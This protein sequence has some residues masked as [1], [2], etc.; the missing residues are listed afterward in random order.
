MGYK[1]KILPIK[2]FS[3]RPGRPF[4]GGFEAIVYAADHGCRV[5]NLSWGSVGSKS[6]YEQ[7]V[8]NYAAIN[9]DAVIVAAAGND[10]RDADYYPAS[11]NNVISVAALTAADTQ[12]ATYSN[13]VTLSAPGYDILTA[14]YPNDN[15][16]A[17]VRGSSF[18]APIVA[19]AAALVRVRFP[20]YTAAQVAAQLRQTTDDIY[21]LPA[22]TP[23]RGKLGTGRLNVHRAVALTDRRQVRVVASQFAPQRTYFRPGEAVRLTAE[24]Q[25]QLRA[26]SGLT[27][28]LTSLSPFLS[29]QRGSYAVGAMPTLGRATTASSPFLLTVAANTP[30]N[31]KALLRYSFTTT[32][33][34]TDEQLL[35]VSLNP[36]YVLLDAG[37]LHVSLNSRSNLGF[38]DAYSSLGEGVKYKDGPSLLA[39]GGLMVGTSATRV[40]DRLHNDQLSGG[41][42]RIDN[43]FESLTQ[44]ALRTQPVQATQ[45]AEAHFRNLPPSG[46]TAATAVGVRV[47]QKASAW[48]EAPHR[49]YVLLEY[50]L[51][52]ITADTLKTLHAGLYLDWDLPPAISQNVAEWDEVG[53]FGYV[54]ALNASSQYAG[55]KHLGGGTATYYAI[56]NQLTTGNITISNGFSTA[57]KFASLSSGSTQRTVSSSTGS[58]VSQVAGASLK[59]LA[60]GDSATVVFAL[61]GGNSLLDLQTAAT[62]AQARYRASVLPIRAALATAAWQ[63]YPN[64]TTGRIRV[65]VPTAFGAQTLAVR[66][67]LG[68]VML[69]RTLSPNA[70]VTDLDLAA[71]PAGLYV[72]QVSGLGGNLQRRVV[73]Q[74]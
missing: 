73:V 65:E 67:A 53:S 12:D 51:T 1:C 46:E 63:V 38:D 29:V 3:N 23:L 49:D 16:Y 55:V 6:Q 28:T 7:D 35:E 71:W 32:D 22:N 14:W 36:D 54:R 5:I 24:L 10:G 31:T 42:W 39:E 72:V 74:P 37:N 43:D 52:N 57:E 4:G 70:S 44:V 9:R 21:Q 45:E 19:G 62:S 30:A 18:A 2:V 15:S 34:Y 66:N 61:L 17:A 41:R 33:G 69:S 50:Q 8:I 47:R 11:Y 40:A 48:A 59:A 64:P 26:V 13:Y 56:D 20:Q 25:N 58:D 60:P 68:Q 27:V